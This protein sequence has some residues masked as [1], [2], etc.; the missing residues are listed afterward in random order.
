[1][2]SYKKFRGL[3]EKFVQEF[4]KKDFKESIFHSNFIKKKKNIMINV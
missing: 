4:S 3:I 1:M 2:A